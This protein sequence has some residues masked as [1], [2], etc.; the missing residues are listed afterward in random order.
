MK[1]ILLIIF[2]VLSAYLTAFYT[3]GVKNGYDDPFDFEKIFEIKFPENIKKTSFENAVEELNNN[4]YETALEY[5]FDALN[6]NNS[7]S[8]NYYIGYIYLQKK[9]YETALLYLNFASN[10]E[11]ADAKI[12]RD[13][14]IAEYYLNDFN[15]AI[16]DLYYATELN[17]EDSKTYYF[18]G[19]CYNE[20]GKKEVAL[21]SV[22]T[23]LLYDSLNIK[24]LY[25]AGYLAMDIENYDKAVKY[26]QK[27]SNINNTDDNKYAMLN[28]GLAYSRKGISDSA[29]LWY[30][31]TI[32][33]YPDYSLAYNN[34]G[35]ILQINK[36]YKEAIKLYNKALKLDSTNTYAL[37]NRADCFKLT[38]KY[39]QAITDYKK[40]YEINPEYYNSLFYTAECCENLDNKEEALNYYLKYKSVAK[41]NSKFFNKVDNKINNLQ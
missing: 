1:K 13:K 18:L 5:F 37:W 32:E 38:K 34:K 12:Y 9:Q 21:Q 15:S 20:Q 26:F 35:Y 39:K 29:L 40:I 25:E 33:K 24:A 11:N 16:N 30:D 6:E 41:S 7:D 22:E 10:F 19:K 17:R 14:G 28:L 3:S 27:Y 4:N 23:A 31:K 2:A 8:V 36:N